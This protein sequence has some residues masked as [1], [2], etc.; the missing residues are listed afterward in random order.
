MGSMGVW[1]VW[2][3]GQR[4]GHPIHTSLSLA[5]AAQCLSGY[6]GPGEHTRSRLEARR[7]GFLCQQDAFGEQGSLCGRGRTGCRCSFAVRCSWPGA[8]GCY[9]TRMVKGR[10]RCSGMLMVWDAGGH[11]AVSVPQDADRMRDAGGFLFRGMLVGQERCMEQDPLQGGAGGQ[12]GDVG[13]PLCSLTSQVLARGVVL[14]MDPLRWR[15]IEVGLGG[16]KAQGVIAGPHRQADV[17]GVGGDDAIFIHQTPR[18]QLQ[19][20]EQEQS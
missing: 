20:E 4:R 5:R 8:Q 6:H 18:G 13:S 11:R 19:R 17:E 3:Y 14:V 2:G 10:G 9:C 12:A 7:R 16:S 1:A 15:G